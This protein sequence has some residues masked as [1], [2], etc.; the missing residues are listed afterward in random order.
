MFPQDYRLPPAASPTQAF[1][2]HILA[3]PHVL[4]GLQT[5]RERRPMNYVPG[6]YRGQVHAGC[7]PWTLDWTAATE[8]YARS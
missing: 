3:D 6:L 7:S 1:A 4:L 8:R 2:G 5:Q